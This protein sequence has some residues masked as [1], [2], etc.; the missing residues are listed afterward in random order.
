M[1]RGLGQEGNLKSASIDQAWGNRN[2]NKARRKIDLIGLGWLDMRPEETVIVKVI[3]EFRTW[4]HCSLIHC[5]QMSGVRGTVW[6]ERAAHYD[7]EVTFL[8]W[9]QMPGRRQRHRRRAQESDRY[10]WSKTCFSLGW[11]N[12]DDGWSF[13]ENVGKAEIRLVMKQTFISTSCFKYC[14]CGDILGMSWK[15]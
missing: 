13:G 8:I 15:T 14:D 12:S 9:G 7:L 1:R 11:I 4:P 6:G 5:Q 2:G 10:L 3:L